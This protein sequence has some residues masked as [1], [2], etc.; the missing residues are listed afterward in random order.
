MRFV[1]RLTIAINRLPI[2]QGVIAL[3]IVITLLYAWTAEALGGIAAITG[4]FLAGLF[5]AKTSLRRQI[6]TSIQGLAYGWLV[7]IFFVSIGLESNVRSLGIGGLPFAL[8]IVSIA[9]FSKIIGGGLGALWGGFSRGEALRLGVGMTSRGEVGL[10][11]A[12]VG[13]GVGLV[14]ED[15]FTSV[16]LMVIATTLLTPIMLRA[17]YPKTTEQPEPVK[18]S[19]KFET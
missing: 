5:F 14:T 18:A 2:S 19:Q 9:I 16:V 1:P 10:I 17:L 11:V 13:L 6:E 15:I 7:P 8:V 3:V 4:A 12:S